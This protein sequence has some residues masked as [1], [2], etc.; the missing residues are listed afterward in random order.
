MPEKRTLWIADTDTS[1]A[2]TLAEYIN[3]QGSMR[4][5]TFTQPETLSEQLGS[6]HPQILLA[7]AAFKA[8]LQQAALSDI[9]CLQ[10]TEKPEETADTLYKFQAAG[11]LLQ[12]IEKRFEE[13]G[14]K[15]AAAAV[16][17]PESMPAMQE[18]AEPRS[19]VRE[20]AAAYAGVS[21]VVYEQGEAGESRDAAM[22][23]EDGGR[24]LC[25]PRQ[26][27]TLLAVYSPVG[28]CGKTSFAITLGEILAF[29]HHVLYLNMEDY[30]GFEQL[31]GD[32][33]AGDLSDMMYIYRTGG[34]KALLRGSG[35][36]RTWQRLDYVPPVFSCDDLR[37]MH[38]Q[39]WCEL[40]L[41]L[42][43]GGGYD[44]VILD[45]GTQVED[46]FQ[47]LKLCRRIYVPG[48]DE[49][50]PRAKLQQFR[51][52][53]EAVGEKGLEDRAR[54]LNLPEPGKEELSERLPFPDRVVRGRM[55]DYVKRLLRSEEKENGL[56]GG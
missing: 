6:V 13:V 34:Q 42:A 51:E 21:R 39:Q 31:T 17:R 56:F 20:N 2:V 41:Q 10:L 47:L 7:G 46:V 24:E 16:S 11:L 22:Q 32:L 19:A 18:K 15:T 33:Q 27:T 35:L 12:K 26:E 29:H 8:A 40:L 53:L 44:C 5:E 25:W 45:I 14:R 55:G 49:V 48:L 52:D 50:V 23:E 37:Q 1:Y 30:S 4:A 36:I 38:P 9:C 28:R 43:E 3:R 54:Y